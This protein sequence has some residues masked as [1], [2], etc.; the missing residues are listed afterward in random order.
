MVVCPPEHDSDT[1]ATESEEA[2]SL[3]GAGSPE[4]PKNKASGESP[5]AAAGSGDAGFDSAESAFFSATSGTLEPAA[6]GDQP[7]APSPSGT[8]ATAPPGDAGPLDK[9]RSKDG[10]RVG[11]GDDGARDGDADG[12]GGSGTKGGGGGTQL[13]R[14]RAS[15]Q[16]HVPHPLPT[17]HLCFHQQAGGTSRQQVL[18]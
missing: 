4:L 8:L 11:W 3:H 5:A 2:S 10:R 1:E 6:S 14:R 7:P 9:R 15:M 13:L 17:W 16:W 18:P 12:G